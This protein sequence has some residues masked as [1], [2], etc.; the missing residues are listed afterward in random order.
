[1]IDVIEHIVE[2]DKFRFAMANVHDCLAPNGTFLLTPVSD[3]NRKHLYYVR[4]WSF[5]D[6]AKCFPECSFR[7]LVPFRISSLLTIKNGR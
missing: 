5:E 2:Q 1:M 7:K 6:I 3:K 4:F